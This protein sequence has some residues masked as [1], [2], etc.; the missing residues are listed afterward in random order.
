MAFKKS[1]L[2]VEFAT[3]NFDPSPDGSKHFRRA[4]YI[5]PD[6]P[7]TVEAA[8]YFNDA[9]NRLPKGTV[10]EAVMSAGGTPV[11]KNFVVVTNTGS[12]VTVAMQKTT[13]G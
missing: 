9:A 8:N 4:T 2:R 7:A 12:A 10:I 13:A 3:G 6:A 11:L 1:A 5:T